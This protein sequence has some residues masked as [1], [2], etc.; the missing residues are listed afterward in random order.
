VGS[1]LA[2]LGTLDAAERARVLA[3]VT[4][5]IAMSPKR[6]GAILGLTDDA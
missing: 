6:R 3:H 1:V 2:A 4:A 5:L